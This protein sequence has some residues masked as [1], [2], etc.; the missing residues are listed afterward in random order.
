MSEKLRQNPLGGPAALEEEEPAGAPQGDVAVVHGVYAHSFP[1]AGVR[2]RD[3]RGQL[4]ERMN[5]DPDAVAVVDGV[6]ADED[7][8]LTE[9]Q[10][11]TFVKHAG[12][13]GQEPSREPGRALAWSCP[14]LG[15]WTVF[16]PLIYS[17]S[18]EV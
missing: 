8:L 18:T 4:S 15:S 2:V 13:K 14:Y 6:E 5:I 16:V 17:Y 7:T 9:G 11:L 12:E 3:A 10:V 1:L